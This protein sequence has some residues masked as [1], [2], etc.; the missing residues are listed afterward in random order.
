MELYSQFRFNLGG[1]S[2]I[3]FVGGVDRIEIQSRC[4]FSLERNIGYT[5]RE[6]TIEGTTTRMDLRRFDVNSSIL[7]YVRV[8]GV[9]METLPPYSR[10]HFVPVPYSLIRRCRSCTRNW[11]ID[12]QINSI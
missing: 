11:L 4:L 8:S 10:I 6:S 7:G 1:R 9:G 12:T 2:L 3:E 5:G